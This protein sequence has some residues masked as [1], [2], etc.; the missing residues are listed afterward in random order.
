MRGNPRCA[1]PPPCAGLRHTQQPPSM[2]AGA[3]FGQQFGQR[4]RL[5]T[6]ITEITEGYDV[7]TVCK[8]LL[9]NADDAGATEMRFV[10]GQRSVKGASLSPEFFSDVP[11][12]LM[13]NLAPPPASNVGPQFHI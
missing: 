2:I 3:D 1:L 11:P 10:L 5:T 12:P 7:H 6:R 13:C 9:Q 8:E 4:V